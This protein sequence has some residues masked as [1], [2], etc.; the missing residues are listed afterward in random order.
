[1]IKELRNLF[2]Y[3]DSNG[4]IMQIWAT[5]MC[6]QKRERAR[7]DNR[8]DILR[9]VEHDLPPGLLHPTRFPQ[10]KELVV[11]G[12]VA[13]RPMLCFG[14]FD[15]DKECTFLFGTIERDRKLVDRSAP[16]KAQQNREDLIRH[17]DNRCKHERFAKDT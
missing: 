7:L 2:D 15:L 3:K 13:L 5:Q 9:R 1:M 10:I 17:P 12:P 16:Q 14:P 6:M 11:N 8:I 4:N